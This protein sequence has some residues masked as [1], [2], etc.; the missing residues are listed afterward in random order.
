MQNRRPGTGGLAGEK[1]QEIGG[2]R[3]PDYSY[4]FELAKAGVDQI[5]S[6]PAPIPK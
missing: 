3:Q 6:R 1:Y 5:A 4:P 2:G